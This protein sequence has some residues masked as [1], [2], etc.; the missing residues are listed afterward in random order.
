MKKF[1]FGLFILG[2]TNLTFSQQLAVVLTSN[3]YVPVKRS[4]T[5]K[6]SDFISAFSKEDMS[7]RIQKFQK[8]VANYDLRSKSIFEA[9]DPSTYEV[10]F[11]EG[12]NKIVTVYNQEGNILSSKGEFE[13]IRLPYV[14]SKDLSK[15][16][17]G[18]EFNKIQCSIN[19][20]ENGSTN[21]IYKVL[22]KNGRNKKTVKINTTDYSM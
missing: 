3:S 13:N 7:S 2:L 19:Y 9:S 17:P 20:S 10:V 21:I 14:I 5:I 4:K 11:K 15:K 6:N 8:I 1:L 18:W 12:S 22:L 16:Y